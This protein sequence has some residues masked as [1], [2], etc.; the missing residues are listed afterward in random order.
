[1]KSRGLLIER[2]AVLVPLTALVVDRVGATLE[3]IEAVEDK[4]IP[5]EDDSGRGTLS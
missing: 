2:V 4:Y 5:M 1:V 3:T